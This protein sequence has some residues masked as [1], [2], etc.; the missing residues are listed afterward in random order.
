MELR[1]AEAVLL[2]RT[3]IAND[4]FEKY[5]AFHT[6]QDYQRVHAPRYKDQLTLAS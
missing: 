6:K 4:D 2:L 3:I 5:W 1:G